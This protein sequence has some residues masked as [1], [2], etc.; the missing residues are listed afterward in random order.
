[1]KKA[2]EDWSRKE[3][4]EITFWEKC[5]ELWLEEKKANAGEKFADKW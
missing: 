1:M 3:V 2:E 4:K 5:E